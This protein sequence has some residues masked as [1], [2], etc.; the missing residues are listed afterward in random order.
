MHLASLE[1]NMLIYRTDQPA[2]AVRKT[3]ALCCKNP[4]ISKNSV[5]EKCSVL[6]VKVV[7]IVTTGLYK[8]NEQKRNYLIIQVRI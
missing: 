2:S 6:N 8:V 1:N 3:V 5:R 4:N 7:H